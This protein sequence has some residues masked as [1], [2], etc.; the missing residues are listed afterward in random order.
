MRWSAHSSA[1][2]SRTVSS[3][4][5]PICSI[6]KGRAEAKPYQ[7][8]K[9]VLLASLNGYAPSIAVE[10]G[11]KVLFTA[12]RPSFKELDDAVRAT[13]TPVARS[14]EERH[15]ERKQS[16]RL[17]TGRHAGDRHRAP[18][19]ERPTITARHHGGA[20]KIA[21]A[22]FVTAMMAFFLLMWLLGSTTK[23]DKEGIEDYF[24]T[25]LSSVLGGNE[26]SGGVASQHV[27]GGGRDISSTR[28][29]DGRKSQTEPMPPYHRA[30]VL[31]P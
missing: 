28:P 29:G 22:D 17:A 16:A 23:Y 20:W 11:R 27:Q 15:H 10:F 2:C 21:Y 18:Y 14:D 7:C 9:A 1:F 26:G 5:W 31:A 8:V 13:K 25:P 12:D 4:R 19:E 24:N 30:A 3:G 6:A